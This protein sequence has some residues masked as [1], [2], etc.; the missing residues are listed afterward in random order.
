[1]DNLLIQECA[2]LRKA[3]EGE[4]VEGWVET[5]AESLR[6]RVT[7]L[8]LGDQ[9]AFAS[10]FGATITDVMRARPHAEVQ[11]GRRVR[12]AGSGAEYLI[13]HVHTA[14]DGTGPHHMLCTLQR[15]VP[16]AGTH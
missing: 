3:I 7:A 14:Q 5:E 16:G 6:C 4:P 15:V 12:L 8:R 13:R 10:S 1:M 2:I 9:Q 11:E